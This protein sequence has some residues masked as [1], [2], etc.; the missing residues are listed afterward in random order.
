[1]PNLCKKYEF[2]ILPRHYYNSQVFTEMPGHLRKCQNYDITANIWT[3]LYLSMHLRWVKDPYVRYI[4][5]VTQISLTHLFSWYIPSPWAY[6]KNGTARLKLRFWSLCGYVKE[7]NSC[8][9]YCRDIKMKKSDIFTFFD[10]IFW[11]AACNAPY[12]PTRQL[13]KAFWHNFM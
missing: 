2:T 1:M 8:Q 10:S 6:R 11:L 4:F 9:Q 5:R 7:V 13:L 12:T 3:S